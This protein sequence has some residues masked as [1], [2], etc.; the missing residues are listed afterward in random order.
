[1]EET[2]VQRHLKVDVVRLAVFVLAAAAIARAEPAEMPQRLGPYAPGSGIVYNVSVDPRDPQV[3]V[4]GVRPQG[5]LRTSDGGK[6]WVH[7]SPGLK[8]SGDAGPNPLSLARAPSSPNRLYVGME[9]LGAFRSD[10]N[11]ATWRTV[12]EGIPAGRA[13]NGVSL[14]VHPADSD[15]VYYGSDGGL[16]RST[17]GG[18]SWSRLTAGLPTGRMRGS[19]DVSQTIHGIFF[20]AVDPKRTLIGMFASGENEP[21]GVWV[22][23]DGGDTWLAS[24]RGIDAGATAQGPLTLRNDW[25]LAIAQAPGRPQT[26]YVST[27]RGLYRSDDF[28]E[29]W[30]ALPAPP[31]SATAIAVHPRDAAA[32]TIYLG[33]G[34]GAMHLSRDG[35]RTW[36]DVTGSLPTGRDPGAQ[37]LKGTFRTPDGREVEVQGIDRQHQNAIYQIYPHGHG[38]AYIAARAGLYRLQ[39][40]R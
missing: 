8:T 11:G 30:Q 4:A 26:L 34:N 15:H 12:S 5:L 31:V 35:G 32:D 37:V 22:S 1:M 21:A 18:A 27:P 7:V 14:A 2:G 39:L 36:F 19:R 25:V 9:S 33:S 20:D 23:G 13:R 38:D 10:D 40:D 6:T 3:M 29:K 24:S 17:D 16:F 28:G